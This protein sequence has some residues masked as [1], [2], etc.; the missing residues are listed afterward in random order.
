M[1]ES[2]L[3]AHGAAAAGSVAQDAASTGE[4]AIDPNAVYSLGSSSGESERLLR[5]AEELASES[6]ALLDRVELGPGDSAIDLGC[7]PCG[8]LELLHRRVFPGGRVVGL[9][10]DPAHV[11][12]AAEFVSKRGLDGVEVVAA[13]ARNTGLQEDSF[14]VVHARTLLIN[15][16]EPEK[17]LAE[18]VRL[19]RPGGWV[20]SLEP[21]CEHS[22]Y[23][24]HHAVFDR[25]DELFM[26]AFSRNGA[27]PLIGRRLGEL[28]RQ[29]VWRTWASTSGPPFIRSG[30][31]D[32]WS[33][34][35]W[36]AR[37]A[38]RS[39]H[40]VQRT[41]ANWRSL[42][43]PSAAISTTRKSWRWITCASFPGAASRPSCETSCISQVRRRSAYVPASRP[44]GR[45]GPSRGLAGPAPPA[46]S[47][48]RRPIAHCPLHPGADTTRVNTPDIALLL[49]SLRNWKQKRGAD[50]RAGDKP[51]L[52]VAN[53]G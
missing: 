2:K 7:G 31:R 1:A 35:T 16:P 11:E 6:E 19:T 46:R 8:I 39:S 48:V 5:Q 33:S 49:R 53:R 51:A 37:C 21:D 44:E 38:R 18:M 41:I 32:E 14:D 40:L 13:D 24:P 20:A 28:Y 29:L 50:V 17:V 30:D 42:T 34:P 43:R 22:I 47:A 15:V 12:M 9:D 36:S 52:W 4:V 3:G 27:D 45:D 10:S 26:V 23:Y 25:L